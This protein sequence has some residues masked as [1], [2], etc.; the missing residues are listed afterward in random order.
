MNTVLLHS[1]GEVPSDGRQTFRLIS[2]LKMTQSFQHYSPR[3]YKVKATFIFWFIRQ[4]E[5][6]LANVQ[7]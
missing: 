5:K 7:F 1:G 4:Y 6:L 3:Q 2:V